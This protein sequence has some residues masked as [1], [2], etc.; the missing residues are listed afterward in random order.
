[1]SATGTAP[2]DAVVERLNDPGVAASLVTLLDNAE[3]LSTLV[4]GLG[5]LI[6][7]S[8]TIMDSVADGVQ[9]FKASG[10]ALRPEGAPSLAELGTVAGELSAAAP[11]LS[12]VLN[13]AMVRPET[14]DLLSMVSEAATEGAERARTQGT[15]VG[16][17]GAVK[18]L[19]DPE[20]QR[21]L[22]V[23]IEIARSLGRR[24]ES[25]G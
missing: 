23:V 14:I 22:G 7:R 3:L 18:A 15:E 20:V 13:S 17:V 4:V 21:G 10:A 12:S 9:E 5:G 1:M 24:M 25:S 6:E 2:V 19:R 8:E 16:P 11:A